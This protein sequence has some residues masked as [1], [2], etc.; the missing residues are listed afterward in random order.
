MVKSS[1]YLIA[2]PS[3]ARI[4]VSKISCGFLWSPPPLWSGFSRAFCLA[5]KSARWSK[6]AR[7][8]SCSQFCWANISLSLL[9]KLSS[10]AFSLSTLG[11]RGG[12]LRRRVPPR[13]LG[14]LSTKPI[15]GA[16]SWLAL[17]SS[18][19]TPSASSWTNCVESTIWKS[20]ALQQM[21]SVSSM[22]KLASRMRKAGTYL[23]KKWVSLIWPMMKPY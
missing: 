13:L 6:L 17:A 21:I 5:S 8:V 2:R 15:S 22:A 19:C 23:G 1:T 11:A 3:L 14:V 18:G 4:I 20:L 9:H 7:I 10:L 12:D 16:G